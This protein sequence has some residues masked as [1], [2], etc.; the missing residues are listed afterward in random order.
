MKIFVAD[1]F[2]TNRIAQILQDFYGPEVSV[3]CEPGYFIDAGKDPLGF[4]LSIKT[5]CGGPQFVNTAEEKNLFDVFFISGR[6]ITEGNINPRNLKKNHGTP[7]AKLV[8]MS[9][10][11]EYLEEIRDRDMGA[12]FF[13]DKFEFMACLGDLPEEI[14]QILNSYLSA[15]EAAS[16]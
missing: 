6:L 11:P 1:S 16:N 13:L 7:T 3:F 12:D 5:E 8:A 9:T 2:N 15:S 4:L 10:L 14:K